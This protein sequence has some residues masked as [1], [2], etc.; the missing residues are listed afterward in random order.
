MKAISST[1][2]EMLLELAIIRRQ[3]QV[4]KMVR[5]RK[6]NKFKAQVFDKISC[7]WVEGEA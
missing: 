3:I 5:E 6:E 7:T 1:C 2:K 4:A